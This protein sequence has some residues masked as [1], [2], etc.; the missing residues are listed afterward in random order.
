MSTGL[1]V[2][3]QEQL[4]E[5]VRNEI[6]SEIDKIIERHK[7]NRYEINKLV[8]ESVAA[9]TSSE[10]YS[11]ELASQGILKR[12]WGGIT[13]KNKALQAEI[14]RN[15]AVAQY[16]SQQSLQKLAEQNLMSF[17]LITAVNNK[18]NVSMV[19]V[20]TEINNIYGTLVTFFKQTKSDIVQLENRVARLERNVNLLNWQNS[21][22]YQM[23]DGTEYTELTDIEKIA[24]IVNDFYEIT[25]GNY[26]TSDLLLLKSAM[27]TIGLNINELVS[28][29]ELATSIEEDERISNKI[30]HGKCE[31]EYVEPW[32]VVVA[33][34]V[35]K[36]EKFDN[37]E[38]Y[39]VDCVKEC[40]DGNQEEISRGNII[41]KLFGEYLEN[42][43]LVSKDGKLKLYDM[44]VELLY[45]I[46]QL[47][48]IPE[49]TDEVRTAE[50]EKFFIKGEYETAYHMFKKLAEEGVPRAMYFMGE[51][52]RQGY[53]YYFGLDYDK[54][55]GFR[56]YQKGAELGDP[57]CILNTAYMYEGEEREKIQQ[58]IIGKIREMAQAGDIFAQNELADIVEGEE[59]FEL[60]K[61]S[62]EHGLARSMRKLGL[63]YFW[64][65]GDCVEENSAEAFKWFMR[66]SE[67][68]LTDAIGDVGNLYKDGNGITQDIN[69]AIE[70]YKKSIARGCGWAAKNMAEIYEYGNNVEK[71]D[72]KAFEW[73][74]KAAELGNVDAM[75]SVALCYHNGNGTKVNK[76]KTFEWCKKAAEAGF[77]MGQNNLA[78][79]YKLGDGCEQNWDKAKEWAMKAAKQGCEA[80]INNLKNWFG[81]EEQ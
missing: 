12:F 61:E 11:N 54:E 24:C 15:Q 42:N 39:I 70:Y 22:E 63:M 44:V 40:L 80:A 3:K 41:N 8:F 59:K 2:V 20:E 17:E 52:L 37:E 21:I 71:N 62:A 48:Y 29:Q 69:K 79:C 56:W 51:Y 77:A 78:V 81:I 26:T 1:Q 4:S 73:Y 45:N 76:E 27:T 32:S 23:W 64:G 65:W 19:E 35:R 33:S 7:N 38:K 55:E 53:G 14:N 50:A 66:A 46:E 68:G 75:N 18:L 74:K 25:Q 9:L 47:K 10:N 6:D 31:N 60:L 57:L 36:L 28:Y 16:A 72:Q 58:S 49:K 43:L 67:L 5:N 34:G 30:F 13:G